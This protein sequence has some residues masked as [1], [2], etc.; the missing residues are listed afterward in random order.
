MY[1]ALA[2]GVLAVLWFAGSAQAATKP[3]ATTGGVA[4]VTFQSARLIGTVNPHGAATTIY[5]QYGTTTKYGTNTPAV[6][7]GAG[8]A[9]KRVTADIG[10]LIPNK[11]YHYRLVAENPLGVVSGTDHTFTTKKQPL[12]LSLVA[13]PNPVPFGGTTSLAGTLTG[14]G[15]AGRAVVLEGNPFPYT[16]GFAAVSNPQLTNA[17]GAFSFPLLAVP[18][19]TQYRV[20][21][22]NNKAVVSPIVN[23]G[24]A[25]IVS[26]H[27]RTRH[28]GGKLYARFSG[29]VQPARDGAQVAFQ[30]K[31][32][33]TWV[34]VNGTI[35]HHASTSRSSYRKTIRIKRGGT[36]RVLVGIVDGNFVSN[37]GR[38]VHLKVHG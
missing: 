29:T 23:V 11:K 33:S 32:G 21:V 4:A 3:A 9:N 38:D 19:N 31:H 10:G 20:V 18:L 12:G 7:V 26:T 6:P 5:F 22:Q 35:T 2:A 16:Q 36:Y 30:R 15:N 28:R 27:L 37:A 1:R 25:V 13:T 14:T 24:V 8:T 17:Q 34:T